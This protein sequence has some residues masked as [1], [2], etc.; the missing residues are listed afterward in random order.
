MHVA[1]EVIKYLL[2]IIVDV[3]V[4]DALLRRWFLRDRLDFYRYLGN[5]E[6]RTQILY[7]SGILAN[8]DLSSRPVRPTWLRHGDVLC[9]SYGTERFIPRKTVRRIAKR[10][11]VELRRNKP[12]KL[13]IIGSSMG[14]V[15]GLDVW[16]VLRGQRYM[17]KHVEF[18]AV[19]GIQ[20]SEN[21][22]GG[23][24]IVAPILSFVPIGPMIGSLLTLGLH[25]GMK[26]PKDSNIQRDLDKAKVKRAAEAAMWPYKGSIWRDQLAYMA[27]H[28]NLKPS[29]FKGFTR[30]YYMMCIG[31]KANEIDNETIK[32]PHEM[33]KWRLACEVARVEFSKIEVPTQHCAY[34]EQPRIW[35]EEF[36]FPL[37]FD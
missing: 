7:L 3:L 1:G 5:P 36:N 10:T 25:K 17:P 34:A 29:Y 21:M 6:A 33:N 22:R 35:N 26:L 8:G 15:L 27:T 37:S 13:V 4:I 20:G 28:D 19:D 30:V 23:G 32:Q 18:I 2:V 31:N 12:E 16:T 14:G 11:L 24:N 9:V